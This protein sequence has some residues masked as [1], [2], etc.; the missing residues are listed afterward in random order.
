[1]GLFDEENPIIH[2]VYTERRESLEGTLNIIR[3][4]ISETDGLKPDVL[5]ATLFRVGWNL[6]WEERCAYRLVAIWHLPRLETSTID[7]L[8][9]TVRHFYAPKLSQGRRDPTDKKISHRPYQSFN[10]GYSK[11]Q[12]GYLLKE[13]GVVGRESTGIWV[14][15]RFKSENDAHRSLRN[16]RWL[17]NGP[18]VVEVRESEGISQLDFAERVIQTAHILK[19]SKPVSYNELLYG[20]YRELCR[21]GM[22]EKTKE[23]IA[24]L[25]EII[26][27]ME[28]TLFAASKNERVAEHFHFRPESVLL[29]GV[30][31]TGKTLI[32]EV[33]A[34]R[35][36]NALFIPVSAIQLVQEKYQSKGKSD[37]EEKKITLFSA[38]K[39]LQKRTNV[40]ICLHCDDIESALLSPRGGLEDESHLAS[41]S[42]L[43]NKLSGIR[44]SRNTIVTGSTNDPYLIDNRFL[45]FGRI[46]Y[47]LHVPIPDTRSRD[48]VL[49][50]HTR[51]M[52][53]AKDINLRELARSTEGYTPAALA[54]ICNR[55]GLGASKRL[56]KKKAKK[57]GIDPFEALQHITPKDLKGELVTE[58]D[59]EHAF[60][61]VSRFENPKEN[62]ALDDRVK[63]YCDTFN[64]DRRIGFH[65]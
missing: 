59:F 33:L 41:N 29:A 50:I 45:R 49:A 46:G 6:R 4:K 11:S 53:L 22:Q 35:N 38:I 62:I 2:K 7:C 54:E 5:S 27:F 24:G 25:N 47:V 43:L 34:S 20:I 48:A 12:F 18:A 1:M 14:Y 13:W 9:E 44:Q 8:E 60:K 15:R 65:T 55:A 10:G 56:A 19:H 26:E 36:Y 63:K 30:K 39:D 61:T 52:P 21:I 42:T 40:R 32:A 3:K 31:G 64:K 17:Y 51:G 58:K 23:E 57:L 28:W 37:E 16:P